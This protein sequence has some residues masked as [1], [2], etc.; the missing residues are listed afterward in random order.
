M[1]IER[2]QIVLSLIALVK[3]LSAVVVEHE[4]SVGGVERDTVV[5]IGASGGEL[6]GEGQI[7][8]AVSRRV[9]GGEPSCVVLSLSNRGFEVTPG[10]LGLSIDIDFTLNV[11]IGLVV[12]GPYSIEVDD[13][14]EALELSEPELE[15]FACLEPV[16]IDA[17]LKVSQSD[18]VTRVV[19]RLEMCGFNEYA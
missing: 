7:E 2:V 18:Q 16:N 9:E 4:V 14:V 13:L 17:F 12:G 19:G 3:L 8:G 11:G 15:D 5:I 1:T 10:G 6:R